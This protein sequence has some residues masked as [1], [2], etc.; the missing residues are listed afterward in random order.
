MAAVAGLT[1][2]R[3]PAPVPVAPSSPLAADV[4]VPVPDSPYIDSPAIA[5]IDTEAPRNYGDDVGSN[6]VNT[7]SRRQ[8][9]ALSSLRSSL[10]S[11][12]DRRRYARYQRERYLQR[13]GTFPPSN[14]SSVAGSTDD[15]GSDVDP[16]QK[17]LS[18]DDDVTDVLYENQ[19]GW[20]IFGFPL[21]SAQSGR[22]PP[23]TWPDGRSS[24]VSPMTATVPDPTWRW[25]WPA[26][27]IDMARD[28]DDDG[29][30]YAYAFT[31]A[32]VGILPW[33]GNHAFF[34]SFVRRRRWL[35][36]RIRVRDNRFRTVAEGEDVR[37][38]RLPHMLGQDY[39]TIHT[40]AVSTV[41]TTAAGTSSPDEDEEVLLEEMPSLPSLLPLLAAADVDRQRVR[42]VS[43]F[44]DN[45]GDQLHHLA[46]KVRILVLSGEIT[47]EC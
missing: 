41:P 19:T 25:A 32:A 44:V 38:R 29:W 45:A 35:R 18:P 11:R 1:P 2:T 23:W 30:E 8:G 34:Q 16:N 37:G 43:L 27:R 40:G 14:L 9:T 26:W 12:L 15:M 36:R 39:F 28:V 33:H 22:A 5:L 24:A 31:S 46:E 3:E 13:S 4:S 17:G 7:L 42:L 47:D 21:Y 20:W 10:R 6:N